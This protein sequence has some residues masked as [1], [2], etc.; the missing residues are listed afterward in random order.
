MVGVLVN[1]VAVMIGSLIGLIFK[2]GIPQKYAD[3]LMV[4]LGL[5]TVYVGIS[6]ALDGKNV[7]IAILSI[8]A[9]TVVGT[10]IDIDKWLNSFG[11]LVEEKF[12]KGEGKVS[13]AQ[14]FVT[15]SLIFCVGS[16]TIVGSLQAGISGNNE[17]LF[18]KSL[19]DFVMSIVL[20]STLGIGVILSAL[21]VL[22]FQGAIALG[23]GVIAPYLSEAVICEMTCVGSLLV[24]AIGTNIM[25][26]TKIKVANYLPAIFVPIALCPLYEFI[27]NFLSSLF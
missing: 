20:T 1:T 11:D 13:I 19:L 8:V 26:L 10:L 16:M 15:A 4:G 23:A 6:G 14:G 12:S 18:T 5:C 22:V 27:A 2:K 17:M 25:G 7:L 3:A 21:F 24:I 9:G